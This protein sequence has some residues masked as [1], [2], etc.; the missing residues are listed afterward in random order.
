MNR[1]LVPILADAIREYYDNDELLDLCLLFDEEAALEWDHER[2][3]PSHLLF[4]QRLIAKPAH[5]NNRRILEALLPSLFIRNSEKIATTSWE[6]Q[7][8]HRELEIRMRLLRPLLDGTTG[9]AEIAVPDNRPFTAKSKIRDLVET[10]DGALLLVDAYVGITTLDCFRGVGYPI[11][12]LTGQQ[13][14]SIEQ[15]FEQA[16]MDFRM[17]GRNIDV[18]LH[19]K[20][21]DRY[22]IFND[23]CWLV[24]GSIKDAGKKALN[25]IECL[26]SK[27]SIVLDAEA[28]W[29]EGEPAFEPD[30]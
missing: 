2:N 20:L 28:K 22:L 10:A 11:R 3:K 18:R 9:N 17:E 1:E 27:A 5:G 21:H 13:K 16:V 29:A 15:G 30:L 12:I 6:R 24:G 25:V 23:R 7:D 19:A 26:D 4:A 14:N 8:Y